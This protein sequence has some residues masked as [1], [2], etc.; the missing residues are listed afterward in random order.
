MMLFSHYDQ[1]IM[2]KLYFTMRSGI[3]VMHSRG[4]RH[5][6]GAHCRPVIHSR[7]TGSVPVRCC[8]ARS[9]QILRNNTDLQI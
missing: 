1:L 8:Q 7:I 4:Q 9:L 2:R 5:K 6:I 3:E